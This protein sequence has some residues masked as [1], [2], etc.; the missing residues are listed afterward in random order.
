MT[1]FNLW[2]KLI[3]DTDLP[4]GNKAFY[5]KLRFLRDEGLPMDSVPELGHLDKLS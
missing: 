2:L 1:D 4:N 5:W 3:P